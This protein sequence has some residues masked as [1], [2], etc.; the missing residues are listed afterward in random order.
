MANQIG[1]ESQTLNDRILDLEISIAVIECE[2]AQART[3]YQF[4]L[5]G[6]GEQLAILQALGLDALPARSLKLKQQVKDLAEA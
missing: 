3:E 6:P 4:H 5:L 2:L 1:T